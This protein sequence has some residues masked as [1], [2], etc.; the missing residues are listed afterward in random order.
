MPK[1]GEFKVMRRLSEK[2]IELALAIWLEGNLEAHSF[3]PA[4]YFKSNYDM[5]KSQM[6]EAEMYGFFEN[7]E[8]TGFIGIDG[9]HIEGLFVKKEYRKRGVGSA[10]INHTLGLYNELTLEVYEKNLRAR[11]FY[12][13]LGFE[14]FDRQKGEATGEIQIEMRLKS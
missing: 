7:G 14:E 9:G 12:K 8:L 6:K 3:I 1:S 5:V 13:N 2:D 4:G 11:E 10:L